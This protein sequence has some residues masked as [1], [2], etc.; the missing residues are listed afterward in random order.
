MMSKAE[1]LG[2]CVYRLK[3]GNMSASE[4]MKF[5]EKD[6]LLSSLN[7]QQ[8][9]QTLTIHNGIQIGEILENCG[10]KYKCGQN[11]F[12]VHIHS[13]FES[14][15]YPKLCVDGKYVMDEQLNNIGRGI[16]VAVIDNISKS[17]IRVSNFDTYEKDSTNL[18]TTLLTLRP[19]DILIAIT[20]D[21]PSSKLSYISRLL[22][23]EMGS[24]FAQNLQFRS[25]WYL[26]TQKGINGY[27]PFEELHFPGGDG[28]GE[29]GVFRGCVPFQLKGT[30]VRPD[31]TIVENTKR[32]VVNEELTASKILH[33]LPISAEII[34]TPF[35]VWTGLTCSEYIPLTLETLIRQ[36]GINV[37]NVIVFYHSNAACQSIVELIAVFGFKAKHVDLTNVDNVFTEIQRIVREIFPK[38]MQTIIIDENVLLSPDF[39][40]YFGQLL[41]VLHFPNSKVVAI[42]AFN[43][44]SFGNTSECNNLVY[45]SNI[46]NYSL[47]FAAMIKNDF[48]IQAN[49]NNESLSWSIENSSTNLNEIIIDE[50]ILIPDVSRVY[51]ALPS[52]N[53]HLS[54]EKRTFFANYLKADIHVNM[55]E[56]VLLK[57]VDSLMTSE[58]YSQTV[59]ALIAKSTSFDDIHKFDAY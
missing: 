57:D 22:F 34:N 21:E 15:K 5:K 7:E 12:A 59:S 10:L 48:I 39:L 25:S 46:D 42:S 37:N 53:V 17:L 41:P 28:W 2:S 13:G 27:T 58:M 45:R 16:N 33:P 51:F 36:P 6:E 47:K 31:K 1:Q 4:R 18:E 56:E 8:Q 3:S 52:I 30:V 44:N 19:G 50:D 49:S 54:D 24:A 35:V 38:A 32:Q 20:F 9:Q 23:H 26:I 29:P 14:K 11:E 40:P 43:D 55:E